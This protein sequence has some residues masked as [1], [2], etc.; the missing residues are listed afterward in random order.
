M[1]QSNELLPLDNAFENHMV[2]EHRKQVSELRPAGPHGIVNSYI[3]T[4]FDVFG[5]SIAG[6]APATPGPTA[7][8]TGSKADRPGLKAMSRPDG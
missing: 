3:E 8:P 2:L 1:T 5:F 4:H 7:G 6:N